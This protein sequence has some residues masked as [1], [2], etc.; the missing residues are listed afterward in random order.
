MSQKFPP[1]IPIS[2]ANIFV[3][4]FFDEGDAGVLGRKC[5]EDSKSSPGQ[6]T[7][8]SPVREGESEG[9]DGAELTA[10]EL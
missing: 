5:T 8:G 7:S 1:T 4:G 6:R 3:T 2:V 10:G 9:G